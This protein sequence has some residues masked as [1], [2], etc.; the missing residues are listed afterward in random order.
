MF[1]V[2][3]EKKIYMFLYI[4]E[5]LENDYVNVVK[6]KMCFKILEYYLRINIYFN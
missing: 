6:W 3:Y 4:F 2:L 5:K 1:Y